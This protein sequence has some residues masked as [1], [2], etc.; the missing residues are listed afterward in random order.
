MDGHIG[1]IVLDNFINTTIILLY[2]KIIILLYVKI[3]L[4]NLT[5]I[6][7]EGIT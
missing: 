6:F 5:I 1:V 7:E 4:L 3:I 2:V